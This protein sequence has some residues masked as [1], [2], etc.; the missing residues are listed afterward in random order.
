MGSCE[1]YR[2]LLHNCH[3][4]SGQKFFPFRAFATSVNA[5]VAMTKQYSDR[6]SER[7]SAETCSEKNLQPWALDFDERD[8][9]TVGVRG[10]KLCPV[11][12]EKT[13]CREPTV[14]A[15]RML[16]HATT[17][18]ISSPSGEPLGTI[19]CHICLSDVRELVLCVLWASSDSY[20][21]SVGGT[22]MRKCWR[23]H[24]LCWRDHVLY[25]R[26]YV[27]CWTMLWVKLPHPK[28][29]SS[30]FQVLRG[31]IFWY[32]LMWPSTGHGQSCLIQEC[33]V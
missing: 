13:R 2:Q 17:R 9:V 26:D 10:R 3:S 27:L 25:W 23:D 20:T 24:V 11:P 5:I 8:T 22:S 19:G 1:I 14:T 29:N 16:L 15:L 30:D 4:S 6:S 18:E 12:P 33:Y 7:Q 21:P 28:L 31:S 32:L